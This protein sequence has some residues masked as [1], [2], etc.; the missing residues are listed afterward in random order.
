MNKVVKKE[1]NKAVTPSTD[2]DALINSTLGM[3][4]ENINSETLATPRLKVAQSADTRLPQLT[5]ADGSKA[6][7]GDIYDTVNL[8]AYDG[9]AGIKL[10]P[11]YFKLVY[12]HWG[13]RG[14]GTGAPIAIYQKEDKR[15]PTKRGTDNKDYILDSNNLPTEEYIEPNMEFYCLIVLDDG[16]VIPVVLSMKSTALKVGRAWNSI[17]NQQS[18]FDENGLKQKLPIFACIYNAKVKNETRDKYSW[19][20]WEITLHEGFAKKL[21]A[22]EGTPEERNLWLNLFLEAKSFA[23]GAQSNQVVVSQDEHFESSATVDETSLS[24]EN[25]PF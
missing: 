2:V 18:F 25:I 6:H 11:C 24:D 15:P 14:T 1:T 23:E 21:Q 4:T 19:Y 7:M 20:N 12:T 16:E 13:E 9:E 5:R 3:G 8:T 17:I 10:V 22:N